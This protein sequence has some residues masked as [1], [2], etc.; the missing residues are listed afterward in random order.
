[1]SKVTPIRKRRTVEEPAQKARRAT[2]RKQRKSLAM[3]S[4]VATPML[5]TL[6]TA[7]AASLWH[8]ESKWALAPAGVALAVLGVS[9]PHVR[10]GF[11]HV[12]GQGRGNALLMAIGIDAGLICFEA[13]THHNISQGLTWEWSTLA[14]MSV[15][16]I[17][18]CTCLYLS[19]RYNIVAYTLHLE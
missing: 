13:I 14:P 2:T 4:A 3:H 15:P 5:A 12:T 8:E 18:M 9:L 10:D 19:V 11:K 1:M 7:A 6:L 16:L 17:G